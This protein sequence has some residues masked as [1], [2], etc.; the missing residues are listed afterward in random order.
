MRADVSNVGKVDMTEL[1][2]IPITIPIEGFTLDQYLQYQ[3][4]RTEVQIIT[5]HL[6]VWK[7]A[8]QEDKE[9]YETPILQAVAMANQRAL[10]FPA[11]E[12]PVDIVDP[13][14]SAHLDLPEMI[15]ELT[16]LFS[17]RLVVQLMFKRK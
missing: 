12:L 9:K 7:T 8:K 2:S 3:S 4:W 5:T 14:T 17:M 6:H 11:I 13:V 15:Q 10:K 16:S 1:S